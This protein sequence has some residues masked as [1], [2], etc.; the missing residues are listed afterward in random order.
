MLPIENNY[1]FK[2]QLLTVHANDVREDFNPP[3]RNEFAF[4]DGIKISVFASESQVV[5]TAIRDF[6]DYLFTS[7]G[8]SAL[9]V[10]NDPKCAVQIR[11][12]KNLGDGDGY[13]GYKI[14]VEKRSLTVEGYD[15]RGIAQGLYYLEDLMN[16]RKAPYVKVG[17]TARKALF[18]PRVTQSPLGMYDWCDQAFSI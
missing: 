17:V 1:D 11:F 9:I 16:L 7:M 3:K 5:M 12:G 15:E 10:K 2:T 4:S 13:M 6:E 18:S 14:T 8:V